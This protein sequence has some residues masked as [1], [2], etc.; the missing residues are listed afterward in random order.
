MRQ[1]RAWFLRLSG[2]FH[3]RHRDSEF[4]D[5]LESHIQ[6]QID[7]NLRAGMTCGEA[8]R[9]AL[10]K[11]GG[12]EST[13]EK[14]SQRHS[15]PALESLLQDVRYG[16]RV[17]GRS[18]G[19]T[20]IA[21]LTLALGIGANTAIFSLLNALVLRTLPVR[22]PERLASLSILDPGGE[23]DDPRRCIRPPR[24]PAR[25]QSATPSLRL[26]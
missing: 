2:A 1:L 20:A 5:E 24:F 9:Q 22:Q 8:R 26:V 10:I 7:D 4:A 3:K 21:L 11:L 6:M 13:K 14:Y 17:L 25:S 15:L 23:A 18:P 16:L 12:V 19:F